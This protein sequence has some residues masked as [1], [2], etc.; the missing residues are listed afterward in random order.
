MLFT[1]IIILLYRMLI[2]WNYGA[3]NNC[4]DALLVNMNSIVNSLSLSL[5]LT[6]PSPSRSLS[7]FKF[8][9]L[10]FL[11]ISLFGLLLNAYEFEILTWNFYRI[12][13]VGEEIGTVYLYFLSHYVEELELGVETSA[14]LNCLY[15]SF[16]CEHCVLS[17]SY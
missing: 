7:L 8:R 9:S 16:F 2:L 1:A 15:Y 12:D 4:K 6:P 17:N 10:F 3:Q 14:R 11:T 13:C 5:S